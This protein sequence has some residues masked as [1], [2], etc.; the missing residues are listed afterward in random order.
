MRMWMINPELMCM[1]HVLG[2][3]YEI[4]KHLP[5]LY[6]GV[7]IHGRFN[8]IIQIQLNSLQSR[9]DKLVKYLKN[10]NSLLEVDEQ[11]IKDNYPKY[12]DLFVDIEYNIKDLSSRC[13]EC[14]EKINKGK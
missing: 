14:C 4:H 12:Y 2:E 5:H 13:K 7:N 8:P 3:H 10:H 9:H 1:K 11:K 6:K